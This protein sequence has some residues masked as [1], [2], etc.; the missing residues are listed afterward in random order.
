M[1]RFSTRNLVQKLAAGRARNARSNRGLNL[2]R[3]I[4]SPG[5][6]SA[7]SPPQR[8]SE[9][10][11]FRRQ[12]SGFLLQ[13]MTAALTEN[14]VFGIDCVYLSGS[15]RKLKEFPSGIRITSHKLLDT[16]WLEISDGNFNVVNGTV[17]W[18]EE[19]ALPF[20]LREFT[21]LFGREIRTSGT[22]DLQ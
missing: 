10:R 6:H 14:V 20:A 21:R 15:L 12:R 7:I 1:W 8:L 19:E 17:Q 3:W 5:V 16:K 13:C 11:P 22:F 18:L 2:G 4:G 9:A